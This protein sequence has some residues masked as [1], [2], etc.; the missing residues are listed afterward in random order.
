V[1]AASRAV[2]LNPNFVLARDVL[3][4]LYLKSGQTER[5]IEQCRRSLGD[6]PSDQVAL[7]H[8]LQALRKGKDPR[9]EIPGLVRRLAVLR[10]RSQ[11]QEASGTRYKLYEPGSPEAAQPPPPR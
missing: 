6:N 2:S 10:E 11:E 1:Q 5:A 8:L 9:G 3:G 4:N 7:Y